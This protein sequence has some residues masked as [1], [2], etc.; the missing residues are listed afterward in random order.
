[1]VL[2]NLV[3]MIVMETGCKKMS[4]QARGSVCVLCMCV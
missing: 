4:A 2:S 3:K 1:M